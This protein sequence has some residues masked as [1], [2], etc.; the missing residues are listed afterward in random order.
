MSKKD[1]NVSDPFA[2]NAYMS[3]FDNLGKDDE[4]EKPSTHHEIKPTLRCPFKD[5]PCDK[6]CR[7]YN[8]GSCWV[9]EMLSD[10]LSEVGKHDC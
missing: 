6:Q 7:A 2:E 9:L 5:R 10:I 8:A 1:T 3:V 4:P